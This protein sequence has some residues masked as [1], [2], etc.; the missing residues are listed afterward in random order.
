MSHGKIPGWDTKTLGHLFLW[1]RGFV[2]DWLVNGIVLRN[3][4]EDE[5]NCAVL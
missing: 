1:E 4:D 5:D 2:Q 3:A